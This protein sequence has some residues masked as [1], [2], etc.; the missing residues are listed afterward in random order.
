MISQKTRSSLTIT[1]GTILVTFGT[2]LL[3]AIAS[4]YNIDIFRGEIFAT[5]LA[6]LST[7]P[8]GAKIKINSKT[9]TQKTPYR[10]ENV[11]AG[12]LTVEYSKPDYYDWRA[13]YLVRGGQVTFADYALLIPRSI[14]QKTINSD[15]IFSDIQSSQE[16][17]R[18]FTFV[19]NPGAIFEINKEDTPRKVADLPPN[20]SLQFPNKLS[21][22][23]LNKE[24]SVILTKASY[25]DGSAKHF[26]V[27]SDSGKYYNTE[28]ALNEA[29]G[30][31]RLNP[32]NNREIYNLLQTK[33]RRVNVE[34]KSTLDLPLKDII[35][36]DL[37]ADFLYAL[38]KD[39]AGNYA[40]NRYDHNGNNKLELSS[41]PASSGVWT[42]RSS[43][44]DNQP[45]ITLL[46]SADGSFYVI[47]QIEGKYLSSNVAK[48]VTA[49]SFSPN[50]RF[51]S[52]LQGA[53]FRT[54]DFK[55]SERFSLKDQVA[56]RIDWLTNY[57]ALLTKSDGL[58]IVDYNGFNLIKIP[59]TLS[60]LETYKIATQLNDKEV[61]SL[62]NGKV[63]FYSL[64]P[65]GSLI[66]FR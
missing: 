31:A 8:S 15:Q 32:R 61:Y 6:I 22:N 16:R 26:W 13:E 62:V 3:V 1:I 2:I 12:N 53:T 59:P 50:G 25:P 19:D 44:F 36:F 52:F 39:A 46:D 24:G 57:Q 4:G 23:L 65:K 37:D 29:V 56:S 55:F 30:N 18:V 40:L 21:E 51:I 28:D 43:R 34:N 47:R 33:L 42:I 11:A 49:N 10:L 27:D 45:I 20:A 41:Y 17:S 64:Q 9:L 60:N 38:Q 5:G 58:Y 66:N 35:S 48:S 54:I 14:E 63:N 7:N